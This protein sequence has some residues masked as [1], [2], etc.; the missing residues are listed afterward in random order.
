M[1]DDL[2]ETRQ[3]I[4]EWVG[5]ERIISQEKVE[6]DADKVL[7]KDLISTLKAENE[8]LDEKLAKSKADMVGVSQ[9]RAILNARMIRAKETVESLSDNIGELENL[10]L[11]LLPAFPSPL[12]DRVS[13]FA[14]AIENPNRLATYSLRERLENTVTVLQAAN[15]FD[16]GVNLEKQKFTIAGK[17]R[18]FHVIYFGFSAGYFVNESATTAGY[19]IPGKEGWRWTQQNGLADEVRKAVAIHSKRAMATFIELPLPRAVSS[20]DEQ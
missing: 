18:E 14:E 2:K 10:A 5:T 7:L 6:W 8:A 12:R 19:G 11:T 9:Q 15:L 20:V 17:A 3:L 13:R 16:Q 4:S 1:G